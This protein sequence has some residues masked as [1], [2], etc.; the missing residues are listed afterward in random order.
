MAPP[1]RAQTAYR[2]IIKAIDAAV[3]RLSLD[4]YEEVLD[5]LEA[6]IDGR[7]DGIKDDRENAE[8]A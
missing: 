6:D 2:T 7:Q 8:P 1:T 3:E 5:E 4:E